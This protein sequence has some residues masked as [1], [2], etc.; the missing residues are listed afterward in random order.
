MRQQEIHAMCLRST[1]ILCFP[2]AIAVL[3]IHVSVWTAL[4]D[5]CDWHISESPAWSSSGPACPWPLASRSIG[6]A[7]SNL[8]GMIMEDLGRKDS[9]SKW[10]TRL[11]RALQQ[12]FSRPAYA[13][14]LS[15][16]QSLWIPRMVRSPKKTLTSINIMTVCFTVM[17]PLRCMKHIEHTT[18]CSKKF[19]DLCCLCSLTLHMLRCSPPHCHI[20]G[21]EFQNFK[22]R[23]MCLRLISHNTW[24]GWLLFRSCLLLD[25]ARR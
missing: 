24:T 17:I 4:Q 22:R 25:L 13:T 9:I 18:S 2:G 6:T 23:G 16:V 19:P 20:M 12:P 11:V 21:W 15:L 10:R 1:N 8:D 7:P 14:R 5:V 3:D